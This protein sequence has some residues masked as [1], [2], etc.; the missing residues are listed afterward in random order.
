MKWKYYIKRSGLTV[1]IS[2][3]NKQVQASSIHSHNLDGELEWAQVNNALLNYKDSDILNNLDNE[4]Y[5]NNFVI[6]KQLCSELFLKRISDSKK[7]FMGYYD[8]SLTQDEFDN[9]SKKYGESANQIRSIIQGSA[10]GDQL[11]LLFL[12]SRVSI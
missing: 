4:D 2:E 7:Y 6:V 12:T 8:C 5:L 10:L 1:R 9:F 11:K 3:D